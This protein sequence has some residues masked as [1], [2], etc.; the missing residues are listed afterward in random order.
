MGVSAVLLGVGP[1]GRPMRRMLC[2]EASIVKHGDGFNAAKILYCRSWQCEICR[3]RRARQLVA[4][5]I[6]G[7]ANKFLTLTVSEA[8]GSD[9]VDRC[10]NLIKAWRK[11]RELI[12]KE[13]SPDGLPFLCVIEAQKNGE[14]HLH[15]MCRMPYVPQAWISQQM[16]RLI[17]APIVDIRDV[18]SKRKLANY[19]AKYCG[20]DPQRF[21][22]CKRYW[23]S[24]DWDTTPKLEKTPW[25]IGDP[26]VSRSAVSI[27]EFE[28]AEHCWARK[29]FYD[30]KWLVSVSWNDE[31]WRYH[32]C[33]HDGCRH[34][35]HRAQ[36]G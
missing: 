25:R 23:Q 3:P 36:E 34:P 17:G 14:P 18:K 24:K 22:T 4:Q 10:R 8:S 33:E 2:S 29:V 19:V 9:P 7:K 16:E 12:I 26:V 27:E 31:R 5:A 21:G 13:W 1:C 6:R 28:R 20:K 11:L 30:G 35:H 15:I 32:H